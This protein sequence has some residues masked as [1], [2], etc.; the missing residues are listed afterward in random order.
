MKIKWLAP[1]V[2]PL[3]EG[4]TDSPIA[5]RTTVQSAFHGW[6]LTILSVP[7]TEAHLVAFKPGQRAAIQ[8]QITRGG[9]IGAISWKRYWQRMQQVRATKN[10]L[11]G[12]SLHVIPPLT[13]TWTE[14]HTRTIS[15]Y[16]ALRDA[17]YHTMPS[18]KDDLTKQV[19]DEFLLRSDRDM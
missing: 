18:G 15:F 14:S 12:L 6:A 10:C 11:V 2:R 16:E 7:V 8:Q 17:S 13:P 3:L 5:F 19:R 1:S 4:S 9:N